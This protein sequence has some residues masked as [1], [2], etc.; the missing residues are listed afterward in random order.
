MTTDILTIRVETEA[1]WSSRIVQA[2]ERG[3]PQPPGYSFRTHDELLDTLTSKR[4]AI[5]RALCGRDPTG[6]DELA[7]CVGREARALHDDAPRLVGIG[8]IDQT[9]DGKLH[10]PY[11]GVHLELDWRAAA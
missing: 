9:E 6:V 11:C 8:L 7:Q 5:L 1:Q 10:F 3:E 2:A 4:F